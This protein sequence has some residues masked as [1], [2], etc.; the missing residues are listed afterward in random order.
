[1]RK[2]RNRRVVSPYEPLGDLPSF[3]TIAQAA[4]WLTVSYASV[5]CAISDG[6]LHTFQYGRARRI[7]REELARFVE[8]GG[9]HETKVPLA[10][11]LET[12]Q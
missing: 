12:G 4:A 3:L 8:T 9:T 2:A 1:M 11:H 10:G 6:R 5:R 7:H